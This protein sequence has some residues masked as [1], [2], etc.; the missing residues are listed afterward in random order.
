MHVAP[1]AY[2]ARISKSLRD[3][4]DGLDHTLFGEAF[5]A[6]WPHA[7][8]RTRREDGP[9]P[10]PKVLCGE[11]LAGDRPQIV[12]DVLGGHRPH[13]TFCVDIT[14]ELLAR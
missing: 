10:R 12:V 4:V 7:G 14:E 11:L 3:D 8:E 5:V 6:R 9:G 13:R 1:A 2:R